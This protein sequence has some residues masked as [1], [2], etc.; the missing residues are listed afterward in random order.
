MVIAITGLDDP[1]HKER[2]M[3]LG[4]THFL[5]KPADTSVIRDLVRQSITARA[6]DTSS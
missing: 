2:I 4:A 1:G 3:S 6:A 5:Q